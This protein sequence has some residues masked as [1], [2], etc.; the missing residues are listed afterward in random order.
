MKTKLI[1]SEDGFTLIEILV[2]MNLSF[3]LITLLVTMYLFTSKFTSQTIKRI[4]NKVE[5]TTSL[6]GFFKELER[7]DCFYFEQRDSSTVLVINNQDTIYFRKDNITSSQL[8][9][10]D[11][12]EKYELCLSI[13]SG[14]EIK[15]INGI[16]MN[17]TYNLQDKLRFE[18]P[19]IN[20][21]SLIL[22]SCGKQYITYYIKPPYLISNFK[23]IGNGN[24]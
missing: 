19:F 24:D 9:G 14:E 6:S 13:E 15:L 18:S 10:L 12:I 11:R 22:E 4:T 5:I 8:F 21:I 1:N 23:N 7:A 17:S 3:I 16:I 20:K 2:S